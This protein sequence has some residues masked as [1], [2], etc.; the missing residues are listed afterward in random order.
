MKQVTEERPYAYRS[1]RTF[2][3]VSGN[4][5][6]DVVNRVFRGSREQLLLRLMDEKKLSARERELLHRLLEEADQ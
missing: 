4:L 2:E 1:I 6:S 5:L 3:E